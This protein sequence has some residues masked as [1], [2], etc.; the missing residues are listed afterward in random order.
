MSD[1]NKSELPA[2][3]WWYGIIVMVGAPLAFGLLTVFTAELGEVELMDGTMIM[4]GNGAYAIRNLAAAV[5]TVFALYRR[6]ESMLL[7]IFIMRLLTDAGD[8]ISIVLSGMF[9]GI[10]M[11]GFLVAMTA[12][13]W[14]PSIYG[15]RTLWNP[16]N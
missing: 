12:I 10:A 16:T 4:T 15:I 8:G 5:M 11:V 9:D 14:G 7:L 13:F 2:W 6:S 3:I 1:T